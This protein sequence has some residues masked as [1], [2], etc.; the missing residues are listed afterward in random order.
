MHF[1]TWP[2]YKIVFIYSFRFVSFEIVDGLIYASGPITM[3]NDTKTIEIRMLFVNYLRSNA[4]GKKNQWHQRLPVS[5]FRNAQCTTIM[6]LVSIITS[7]MDIGDAKRNNGKRDEK[8]KSIGKNNN[9]IND[10]GKII[11]QSQDELQF[12]M[13]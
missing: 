4:N 13:R 3:T 5:Y 9:S 10:K 7:S 6:T 12:S 8:K 2:M 1:E 11:C